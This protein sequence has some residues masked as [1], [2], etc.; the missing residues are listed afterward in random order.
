MS[1]QPEQLPGTIQ[2]TPATLPT[3]P[4]GVPMNSEETEYNPLSLFALGA[5]VLA[6]VYALVIGVGAV[7]SLVNRTPLLLPLWTL[8][9]PLGA[10]L[11]SWFARFRIQTSEGTL[12]GL[13]L[14][15]WGMGLGLLF[16]LGYA[17]YYTATYLAVENQA[18][19]S[20]DEWTQKLKEGDVEGAFWLTVPP[21]ARTGGRE[22]LEIQFNTPSGA[23]NPMAR[24]P[25][26]TI[27]SMDFIRL[28]VLGGKQTSINYLGVDEWG[29]ENNG[30][31]V[32]LKYQVTTPQVSFAMTIV[33][34][35]T[36]SRSREKPGRQ[37]TVL[38]NISRADPPFDFTKDGGAMLDQARSASAFGQLW[39]QSANL[40][41]LPNGYLL[42]L[43]PD[44]R[45]RQARIAK[46]FGLLVVAGF[47]ALLDPEARTFTDGL[48]RYQQGTLVK[49]ES[50]EFW[51]NPSHK[52][53]IIYAVK[54]LFD[55]QRNEGLIHIAPFPFNIPDLR[56]E[57]DEISIRQDIRMTLK[58]GPNEAPFMVEGCLV[59]VENANEK[60][61][62]RVKSFE[63]VRGR[64][65]PA[66][67][68]G[69]PPMPPRP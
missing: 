54:K 12:S 7:M 27:Q 11:A 45:D 58:R 61:R 47:P 8:F 6:A 33:T 66:Q 29:W 48:A 31:V 52:E 67:A 68:G 15:T 37:W 34:H 40:V 24:G 25:Y 43:P 69:P 28:I 60:S 35:G 16:G 19:K 22:E 63:L 39:V 30:F 41:G 26:S 42:T 20:V 4:P 51:A 1:G 3:S 9:I 59:L 5:M 62:W 14:T 18:R 13:S 49:A 38:I 53:A 44:E 36:D 32:K 57:G 23:P 17:A 55:P 64:T 10:V 65:A 2:E 50:P 56:R 21:A 46:R